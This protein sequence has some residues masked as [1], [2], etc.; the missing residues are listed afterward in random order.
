MPTS[1]QR[2]FSRN[3]ILAGLP[4][5][6][7]ERLRP[8]F[9]LIAGR[10]SDVII[11]SGESVPFI[12]FPLDAVIS[13]ITNVRE[14]RGVEV[15]LIGSEGFVGIWA[16][17]ASKPSWHEAV[18]QSAGTLLEIKLE[19]F[20]AELERSAY[21]RIQSNRYLLF[22]LAQVS[23]TAACNRLHRLEQ[24]LARWLL[25][26]QDQV[27][28]HE[29]YQTH[30]FLSHMLGS[31]RSEVTIAA[32]ILRTAGLISYTRGKVKILNRKRLEEASCECYEI[33]R[34]EMS[35]LS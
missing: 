15:A 20:Q 25:M 9:N 26:S 24:R 2:D 17:M 13:I 28:N 3:R 33:V 4:P 7:L 21:L 31:D 14:G 5:A 10:L 8:H 22:L 19:I 30:E 27:R 12:Y 32:G 35:L 6:E 29:F 34:E 11:G 18:V 1:R 16:A 23:Q